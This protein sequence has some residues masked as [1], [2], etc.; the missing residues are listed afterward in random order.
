M[1]FFYVERTE[2]GFI[3]RL[4]WGQIWRPMLRLSAEYTWWACRSGCGITVD[5]QYIEARDFHQTKFDNEILREQFEGDI[6]IIHEK[7][8]RPIIGATRG[9]GVFWP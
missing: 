2:K 5:V 6:H 1:K 7:G 8:N 3:M 4:L 9:R